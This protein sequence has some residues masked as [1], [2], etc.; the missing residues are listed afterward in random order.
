M[1]FELCIDIVY[2]RILAAIRRRRGSSD[3]CTCNL[4]LYIHVHVY[5]ILQ[6]VIIIFYIIIYFYTQ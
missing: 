2:N 5:Y 1:Q 4:G 6:S 3:I